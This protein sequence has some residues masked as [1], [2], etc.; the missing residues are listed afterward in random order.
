MILVLRFSSCCMALSIRFEVLI[1]MRCRSG[2]AKTV[3][4]RDA[5]LEPLGEVRMRV[6]VA[7]DQLVQCG[8]CPVCVYGV[9]HIPVHG[10]N[11]R[12]SSRGSPAD[13]VL[14]EM[15]MTALPIRF[16][17]DRLAGGPSPAWSS[18]TMNS[19][20]RRS[21]TPPLRS[22]VGPAAANWHTRWYTTLGSPKRHKSF[23]KSRH[24]EPPPI[25]FYSTAAHST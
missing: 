17:E 4:L 2:R 3:A 24:T 1:E 9:S 19:T 12:G 16:R 22:G 10:P 5:A 18:W 6:P 20:Q 25:P 11:P 8:L 14:G 13:D 21:Q 23:I 15:G 7:V